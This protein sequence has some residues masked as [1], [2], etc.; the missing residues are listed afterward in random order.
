MLF[1]FFKRKENRSHLRLNIY[2]LAK[3]SRLTT[4]PQSHVIACSI[5]DISRGGV[6][7]FTDEDLPVSSVIKVYINFP[8][9]H[10]PVSALAKVIWTKRIGKSNRYNIGIQFLDIENIFQ[11]IIAKRL[12]SLN[13]M[14]KKRR[15]GE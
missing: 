14:V 15:R 5:E 7:L 9:F 1:N 4:E 12:D 8:Q 13:K 6:C 3:Y 10:Q 2:H 11:E